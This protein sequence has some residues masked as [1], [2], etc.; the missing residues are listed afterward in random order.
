MSSLVKTAFNFMSNYPDLFLSETTDSLVGGQRRSRRSGQYEQGRDD[1]YYEVV[2][3]EMDDLMRDVGIDFGTQIRD[4][5]DDEDDE[6]AEEEGA[7]AISTQ[8]AILFGL[9][10][11]YLLI[12]MIYVFVAKCKPQDEESPEVKAWKSEKSGKRWFVFFLTAFLPIIIWLSIIGVLFLLR[13]SVST[14][15]SFIVSTVTL[16]LATFL[17]QAFVRLAYDKLGFYYRPWQMLLAVPGLHFLPAISFVN[18]KDIAC[19]MAS[20]FTRE[21]CI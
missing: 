12:F 9:I 2:D 8:Y 17:V 3:K 5:G 20:L 7:R 19:T 18:G 21:H 4:N 16:F 13:N 10:A 6:E 14:K 1:E 15:I 11:A